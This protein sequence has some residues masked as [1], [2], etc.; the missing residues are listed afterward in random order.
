VPHLGRDAAGNDLAVLT[1]YGSTVVERVRQTERPVIVTGT[2]EGEALGSRSVVTHGLRSIMAAPMLF[3]GRLLGVVYLDS[4]VAKGMFATADVGILTAITN[5]IAAALETTRAA[6][7]AVAVRAAEQERDVANKLCD[8]MMEFSGSLDPEDVLRRLRGTLARLLPGESSCLLQ[9]RGDRMV[10]ARGDDPDERPGLVRAPHL[11]DRMLAGP[12]VT[13]GGEAAPREPAVFGPP[14][15]DSSWL[16]VPLRNHDKVVG[17]VVL[18]RPE[19]G[20]YGPAEVQMAAALAGEAMVAYDNA[21]LFAQVEAMA[22]TDG[23]TAVAN[24][25]HFFSLAERDVELAGGRG[26]MTAV[27]LDIDHFK[28]IND[29]YGHQVGDQVIRT[30]ADRLRATLRGTDRLGRYGGEEFAVLLPEATVDTADLGERLRVAVAR[31]PIETDAGPLPVTVS[32]GVRVFE[33]A[34]E[35]LATALNGADAALYRAKQAGRNRVE[36]DPAG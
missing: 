1:D 24:R 10:A 20:A 6:Q 26:R 3:D 21:L 31:G 22:T 14:R 19:R 29:E 35:D 33:P 9:V 7:L 12:V 15:P 34:R 32:V 36:F 4:R 5:H 8:A 17:A 30:V 13:G 16:A 25:R 18:T 28:R 11:L 27:M 2:D 23:L